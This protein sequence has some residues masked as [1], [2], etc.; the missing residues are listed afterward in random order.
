MRSRIATG[1]LAGALSIAIACGDKKKSP[2]ADDSAGTIP[3][4]SGS[5]SS[6]PP[7]PPPSAVASAPS[8]SASAA[9]PPA[10]TSNNPGG[11]MVTIPEGPV[12]MGQICGAVPRIT[13]EELPGTQLSLHEFSID[14]YPYPNDPTQPLKTNVPREEAQALCEANGKRLCSEVEWEKACKGSL[15]TTFEYGNGYDKRACEKN[16]DAGARDK[17][18]SSY[19]VRD[20]HGLAFEWTSSSWGRDQPS[21]AAVRG[22]AGSPNVVRERCAAGQ[23]RDPERGFNDVGFRCC[24]GPKNNAAVDLPIRRAPSALAEERPTTALIAELMKAMPADHQK[25]DGGVVSFDRVWRWRPRPNEELIVGRW[26]VRMTK[27][28]AA[29]GSELAVFKAC[30]TAIT[31]VERM[32]GPVEKLDVLRLAPTGPEKL[33]AEVQTRAQRGTVTIAYWFGALDIKDPPF[34]RSG[35]LPP[36][37]RDREKKEKEKDREKKG[38]P[39]KPPTNGKRR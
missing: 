18:Q 24:A 29:R 37:E 25:V 21:L 38:H 15:G 30:G 6:A 16:S 17:C 22:Y 34:I 13:D 9:P 1:A 35:N 11:P 19:G 27:P 7:A 39:K 32:K 3:L 5:A 28:V 26:T 36:Q 20:M 8:A 4:P 23:A 2:D 12:T 14:V 31:R 10:P 33:E